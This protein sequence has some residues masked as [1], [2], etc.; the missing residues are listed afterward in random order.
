MSRL[1]GR[2]R[3][4]KFDACDGLAA[5][6]VTARCDMDNVMDLRA[7]GEGQLVDPM[8]GRAAMRVSDGIVVVDRVVRGMELQLVFRDRVAQASRNYSAAFL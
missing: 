4:E 2:C 7:C 1:F 3:R 8:I 6:T 5:A